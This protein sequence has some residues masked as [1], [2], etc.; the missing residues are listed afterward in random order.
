MHSLGK[1]FL[2][3]GQID[4]KQEIHKSIDDIT[5]SQLKKLAN[6]FM[7]DSQISTLVFDLR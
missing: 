1:S 4:T 3:F 5:S 2:A 6:T 7:E